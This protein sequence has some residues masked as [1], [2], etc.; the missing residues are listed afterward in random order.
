[1]AAPC[2]PVKQL[3]HRLLVN[4]GDPKEFF[5]TASGRCLTRAA[6][7]REIG[8]SAILGI[9]CLAAQSQAAGNPDGTWKWS[10]TTQ[11]GQQIDFTLN[12]KHEGEKLTG[13]LMT[14]FG[15]IEIKD[16]T[17]KNDEVN[18]KT[19]F[20]R[21]GNSFTTKYSGKVDGDTIKGQTERERNGQ[22]NKRDWEAKREKK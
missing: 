17:F 4:P 9:T 5:A 18:F 22:V 6:K 2:A 21:D 8:G 10:F 19:V 1:M 13:T 16:G 14:G 20:E 11:N 7:C 15:D 12:L 3:A